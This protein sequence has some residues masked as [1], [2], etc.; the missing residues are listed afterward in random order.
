MK[1]RTIAILTMR[2]STVKIV[3]TKERTKAGADKIGGP[4]HFGKCIIETHFYQS[5]G[6]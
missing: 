4:G 6:V 3:R 5:P 1:V 2:S